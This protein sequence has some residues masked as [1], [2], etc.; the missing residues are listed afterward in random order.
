MKKVWGVLCVALLAFSQIA[1]C[2]DATSTPPTAAATVTPMA[3]SDAKSPKKA[4]P[5][6]KAPT[7][8]LK[9][10]GVPNFGKL[11]DFIWRSGQPTREGYQH[12]AAEGLK[13]VINLREEFPQ[14][15]DLLP[16]GIQYVYI[17]I[18]DEHAPTDDQAKLLMDTVNNPDNW[19]ILIHCEGG[20]GRAGTMSALI[21]HS[22]DNWTDGDIMKEVGNYRLKVLG[23]FSVSMAS[24]QKQYI[25]HWEETPCLTTNPPAKP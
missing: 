25:H 21:R 8:R 6:C 3:T 18:K 12:L 1:L 14:D 7:H 10:A 13:T 23:L 4:W 17:P 19:P 16:K 2:D 9:E 11:N 5:A 20:Q 24:C 15:K 22:M